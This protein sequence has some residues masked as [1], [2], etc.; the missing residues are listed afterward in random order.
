MPPTGKPVF[1]ILLVIAS[2]MLLLAAPAEAQKVNI[3]QPI[4]IEADRATIS[5]KQGVST[6]NGHVVLTQGSIK[7]TADSIIVHHEQGQLTH[8]TAVG[9]PVQYDQQGKTA[10]E[11]IRG[12]AD[13]MEFFA[14]EQRLLLIGEAKLSQGGNVFSGNQIDYDTRREVVSATVSESGTQRVHVTIQPRTL[15]IPGSTPGQEEPDTP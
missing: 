7:I 14:T 5:E 3:D 15:N 12:Q 8:V 6:Y 11:D 4:T 1:N 9:K 10:E 13:T 2:V